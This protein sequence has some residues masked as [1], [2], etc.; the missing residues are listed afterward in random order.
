V[1]LRHTASEE[2]SSF[3]GA[4]VGVA[5]SMVLVIVLT[6][7]TVGF[8]RWQHLN[9]LATQAAT[10]GALSLAEGPSQVAAMGANLMRTLDT[11]SVTL[12][13]F[14]V[15]AHSVTV[16]LEE[17]TSILG[18]KVPLSAAARAVGP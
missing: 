13:K 1:A 3:V 5:M 4:I 15:S 17:S 7:V 11:P 6:G 14:Q 2:G 16:A 10:L 18:V 9:A 12:A 8:A